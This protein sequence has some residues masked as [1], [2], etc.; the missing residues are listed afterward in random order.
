MEYWEGE[1]WGV[2]AL[3]GWSIGRVVAL[4]GWSVGK[5]G[6]IEKVEHWEWEH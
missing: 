1:H 5:G 4:G 2:V 6:S 3:G